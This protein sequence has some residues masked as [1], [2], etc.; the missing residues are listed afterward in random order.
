[1]DVEMGVVLLASESNEHEK[2][3]WVSVSGFHRLKNVFPLDQKTLAGNKQSKFL[4]YN[5]AH[6]TPN[7]ITN[8]MCSVQ[9]NFK[10]S[11]F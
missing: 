6:G 4:D 10:I 3:L 8:H 11:L 5:L 7:N 1:M 9:R 2:L